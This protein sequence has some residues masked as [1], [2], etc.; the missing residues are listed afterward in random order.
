MSSI[1]KFFYFSMNYKSDFF[2][3]NN[4][5]G[6]E[7]CGYLPLFIMN[8][9][10]SCNRDNIINKW[11]NLKDTDSYGNMNRFYAELD[12]KNRALLEEYVINNGE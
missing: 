12:S 2:K 9:S 11:L 3:W 4:M 10:W 6:E 8:I 5:W 1:E 7:K